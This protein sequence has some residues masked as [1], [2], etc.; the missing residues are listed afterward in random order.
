MVTKRLCDTFKVPDFSATGTRTSQEEFGVPNVKVTHSSQLT[1]DERN[2]TPIPSLRFTVLT[3]PFISLVMVASSVHR[4]N[5]SLWSALSSTA[6]ISL[7]PNL[8]LLLFPKFGADEGVGDTVQD[9]AILLSL[10]QALAAGGLL[11]D[12]FL[13][14]LPDAQK[15]D[16]LEMVGLRVLMGFGIFLCLDVWMRSMGQGGDDHMDAQPHSHSPLTTADGKHSHNNTTSNKK[17]TW[18]LFFQSSVLLNLAA[19][20]LHNLTDGMAIGAAFAA[21]TP[22]M[23][24]TWSSSSSSSS[25]ATTTTTTTSA[26]TAAAISWITSRGGLATLSILFHEIPHELGDFCVLVRAGFTRNQAIMLQFVT[27]MAAM[28]GSVLGVYSVEVL[29]DA[30]L[31]V[32]AGGFVY[33]STVTL[34]PSVLD[35]PCCSMRWRVAQL[36][37]FFTGVALM[38][39]VVLLEGEEHDHGSHG[40]GHHHLPSTSSTADTVYSEL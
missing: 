12:V 9:H 4:N 2:R 37:A 3:I 36:V 30:L 20:S 38:Y 40:G 21:T 10:G 27:A 32:T 7:A 35:M 16:D 8:I 22:S 18:Q 14:A 1:T 19:D 17:S 6:L 25:S 28:M 13:H 23:S 15:D 29:G 39:S 31:H 34:L 5:N 33:L 11:G 24:N 26:A